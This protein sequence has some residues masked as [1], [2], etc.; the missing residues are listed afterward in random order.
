MLTENRVFIT[1]YSALTP[2][3]AT[4]AATWNSILNGKTGIDLINNW[5]VSTWP[6]CLGGEIK[7]FQAS[8]LIPE[9]K[10]IKMI[11]R[12]DVLGLHVVN[13]AVL[14]SG[15]LDYRNLLHDSTIFNELTGIYVGS[16]GNKYFQQ[17]DF[18]PL[19]AKTQGNMQQFA[20]EIF[21]S[22]HPTWLLR[23]LPNNVLAYTAINYG[24]KGAN[25]NITN[26]AVGSTQA[27]IE[28]YH[29]IKQGRIERAVIVGYDTGVE[30][31]SLFYYTKLGIISPNDLKPFDKDHDGTILAEGAAAIILESE[32][33]VR[34]RN[35]QC[36]AEF[37]GGAATTE[38]S[39]L[40]AVDGSGVKLARLI[41]HSMQT[42]GINPKE[43]GMIV[44]H[45]N[46]GLKSDISE[47]HALHA[48]FANHSTPV[49]A[50]KWAFGHTLVA[51]G[52]IDTVLTIMAMQDNCIPG[53]SNFNQLAPDCSRINIR[54]SHRP[55]D[56]GLNAMI[57]NRGFASMNSCIFLKKV[58]ND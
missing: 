35:G 26:H 42:V 50:F 23:I 22:V 25:H 2:C 41:T 55:W 18:L 54:Q 10:L 1:G 58:I 20:Q 47:T 15:W 33:S 34:A 28:A 3:G 44:A 37:L 8:K 21:N 40:F 12:Q 6:H 51:S 38:A 32:S 7:D 17:Y 29:A 16:P 30:P 24:F 27:L 19:L 13:T 46:G 5:D 4:A 11:S 14:H 48:A 56:S 45:G 31:Q 36:Y 53:I 43:I 57:I 49:T 39:G 52:I 9:K